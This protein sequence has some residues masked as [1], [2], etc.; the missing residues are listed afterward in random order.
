MKKI[1]IITF[2]LLIQQANAVRQNAEALT[3]EEN[4]AT[5]AFASYEEYSIITESDVSSL[6]T[7]MR[8][9][10]AENMVSALRISREH[11]NDSNLISFIEEFR[12]LNMFLFE[13]N[14]TFA[15]NIGL[16]F[17]GMFAGLSSA[18]VHNRQF[19]SNLRTLESN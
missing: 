13:D 16:M 4:P 17:D 12:I 14:I 18:Q 5:I 2:L 7:Q 9:H 6:E 15:N 11:Q 10:D 1:L 8:I 3:T 19:M